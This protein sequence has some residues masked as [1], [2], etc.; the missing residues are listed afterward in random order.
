MKG[1]L[2]LTSYF[3]ETAP[4]FEKFVNPWIRDRKVFYS[5]GGEY[6]GNTGGYIEEGMQCFRGYGV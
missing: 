1:R 6:G 3:A 2:F 4:L 5:H